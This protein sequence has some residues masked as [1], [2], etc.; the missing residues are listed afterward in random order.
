MNIS[1]KGIIKRMRQRVNT[2]RTIEALNRLNDRD[3]A[4][5]GIHRSQIIS[6]ATGLLDIHRQERDDNG[7]NN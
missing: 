1:V 6:V 5:I 4:D 7:D 2:R 3:L